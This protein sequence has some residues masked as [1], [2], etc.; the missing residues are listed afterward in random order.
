MDL[1]SRA[2]IHVADCAPIVKP[3]LFWFCYCQTVLAG[4]DAAVGLSILMVDFHSCMAMS[5]HRTQSTHTTV[6]CTALSMPASC[7][8]NTGKT[9]K[10]SLSCWCEPSEDDSLSLGIK[11]YFGD[12]SGT[13]SAFK[14]A[15]FD[16]FGLFCSVS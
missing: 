11:F 12:K 3:N 15:Y 4:F 10:K 8:N 2:A 6:C 14:T 13:T 1:H 16:I 9:D 7:S 5:K